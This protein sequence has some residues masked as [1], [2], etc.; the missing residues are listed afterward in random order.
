MERESRIEY[1]KKKNRFARKKK[2]NEISVEIVDL[3]FTW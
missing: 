1:Q 2:K 3:G